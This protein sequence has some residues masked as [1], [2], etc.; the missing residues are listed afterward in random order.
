MVLEGIVNNIAAF[1]AFVD[2]GIK[3]NGLIHVSQISNQFISNPAQILKLNQ[4]V[5]VKILEIDLPRKRISLSM[6]DL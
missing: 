6:K 5:K 2:L 4:I 1:G 3:E